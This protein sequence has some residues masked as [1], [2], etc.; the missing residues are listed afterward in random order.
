MKKVF[1]LA[2]FL[3][4]SPFL[5][6]LILLPLGFLFD[7]IDKKKGWINHIKDL[8]IATLYKGEIL[9]NKTS[10]PLQETKRI[11]LK[12]RES[13]YNLPPLHTLEFSHR[14][15]RYEYMFLLD[16]E[17]EEAFKKILLHW[18]ENKV[19]FKEVI[20]SSSAMDLQEK[21]V[22]NKRAFL[23]EKITPKA[24]KELQEK[25]GVKEDVFARFK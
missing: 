16:K 7:Y 13:V 21:S 24:L 5:F 23:M 12:Y 20:P 11:L 18:Y 25:Y 9:L 17:Q 6:P 14:I 4:A 19:D 22:F 8:G 3:I 15:T 10:Y 1:I 2:I